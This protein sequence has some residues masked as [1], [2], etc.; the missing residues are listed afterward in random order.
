[1]T[2]VALLLRTFDAPLYHRFAK[3]GVSDLEVAI[4]IFDI[5]SI[6][7]RRWTEEGVIF[8]TSICRAYRQLINNIEDTPLEIEIQRRIDDEEDQMVKGAIQ[9]ARSIARNALQYEHP[10]TPIFQSAYEH[11]ELLFDIIGGGSE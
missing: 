3:G 2:A 7:H 6:T 1:M 11:T 4:K 10:T 8:Q 5:P 9:N